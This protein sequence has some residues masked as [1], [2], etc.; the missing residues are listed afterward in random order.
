M[1]RSQPR[2]AMGPISPVCA[3]WVPPQA[4][5]SQSAMSMMRSSPVRFGSLRSGSAAAS[6]PD[7]NRIVTG[8]CSRITALAASSAA[9][10][11]A[12]VTSR[13][14]SMVDT[15]LPR[16]KLTVATFAVRTK[17]AES[18]CWPLCCCR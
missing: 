10:I 3:T 13:A 6:S 5:T 16:W 8:R 9:A 14:R 4:E 17:A 15:A 2:T 18:T 11:S 7:T 12:G 1:N